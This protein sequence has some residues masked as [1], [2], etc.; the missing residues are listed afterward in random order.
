MKASEEELITRWIDG[1]LEDADVREL[2]EKY[3]ELRKEKARA[4]EMREM[5]QKELETGEKIPYPDFFNHQ[6][7]RRIEEEKT[8]V[9]TSKDYE[10]MSEKQ[11]F[12]WFTLSRNVAALALLVLVG[13]FIAVAYFDVRDHGTK[14]VST[15]T[16][17]PG[18]EA[19]AFY[20]DQA[21]ASV[22]MLDGLKELPA[23]YEIKGQQAMSY[24]PSADGSSITLYSKNRHPVLVLIMD[25]FQVPSIYEIDF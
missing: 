21:N 24:D 8:A 12:P 4:D 1:E 9:S 25:R 7:R 19:T 5:L 23:S 20:S 2:L 17:S 6:I 15:Y 3:P 13:I 16:P 22:L 18:V 14:I 11:L 10:E